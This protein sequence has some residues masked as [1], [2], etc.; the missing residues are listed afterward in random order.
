FTEATAFQNKLQTLRTQIDVVDHQL[1]DL[2]GKRMKIADDI[3]RLKK[4]NNVAILQA[5]PW[6]FVL[7]SMIEAGAEHNLSEEFITKILKAI[8]EESISHQHKII[9]EY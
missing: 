2:L 5:K 7:D 1:I 4:K 6:N 9:S 8:H 3:G